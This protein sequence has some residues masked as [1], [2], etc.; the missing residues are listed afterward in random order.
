MSPPSVVIELIL[1]QTESSLILG[2]RDSPGI[3]EGDWPSARTV[4]V[5]FLN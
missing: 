4:K 3:L 5:R 2:G 1:S